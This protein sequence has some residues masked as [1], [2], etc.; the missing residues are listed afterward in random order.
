MCIRD[1][2]DL[3]FTKIVADVLAELGGDTAV[4]ERVVDELERDAEIHPERAAGGLLVLGPAG[5]G[6]SD[7]AGG[8]EELGGLAADYCEILVLG[9]LGVLGG[10]E[11]HHLA[12]GDDR[13]R[14]RQDLQRAQ[15]AHLDHHLESLAQQKVA[16][17]HA[18]FVA[19][20]HAGGELAA[21][22]LALVDHVIVE[23][24]RGVH[25][26]DGGRELDVPGAA[27]A[28]ELRHGERQHR[29]QALA[30][31]GDQMVGDLR[32]HRHFRARAGQDRRVHP[33]H[34]GRHEVDK[35]IDCGG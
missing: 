28:R 10:G 23:E 11:L 26:L 9:R 14:R 16:D 35:T 17:E 18:R 19:P 5:D 13:G 2:R 8:G 1:R 15:R 32:D 21:A 3:A 22:H 7:L 24:R 30:S 12:L 20:Q 6:R 33:L 31:G 27:V 4:V 25:E 29:A 34:V